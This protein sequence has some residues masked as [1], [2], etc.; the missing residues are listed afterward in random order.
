V[1]NVKSIISSDSTRTNPPQNLSVNDKPNLKSIRLVR[2]ESKGKTK[3]EL[4]QLPSW[5]SAQS[6]KPGP[7][8]MDAFVSG[9]AEAAA[10]VDSWK[11]NFPIP[12]YPADQFD[13]LVERCGKMT[14][15]G[16]IEDM[17]NNYFDTYEGMNDEG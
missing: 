3:V 2:P 17:R 1:T 5:K 16:P 15:T 8:L 12:L 13:A 7:A 10:I 9:D 11:F 14:F 6:L 4:K